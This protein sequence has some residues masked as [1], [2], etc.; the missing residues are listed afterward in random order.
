KA[1]LLSEHELPV[2]R[3]DFA[4]RLAWAECL[5]ENELQSMMSGYASLLEAQIAMCRERMRRGSES[6]A[7]SPRELAFW[8]GLE[9]HAVAFY[10]AELR[11][12]TE[13]AE[14]GDRT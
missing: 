1:W 13:M 14:V 6:P 4:S 9:E 8:R 7:R 3:T 5:D 2:F 12:L 11:W 10:E